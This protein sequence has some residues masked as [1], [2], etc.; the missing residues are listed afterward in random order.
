MELIIQ[1]EKPFETVHHKFSVQYFSKLFVKKQ[2]KNY[3]QLT[4][5]NH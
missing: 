3:L 1:N 5:T 4:N 2:G